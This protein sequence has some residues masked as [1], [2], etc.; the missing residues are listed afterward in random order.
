MSTHFGV[1]IRP[2]ADFGTQWIFVDA[3]PDAQDGLPGQ[4]ARPAFPAEV[5]LWQQRRFLELA[6]ALAMQGLPVQLP[7]PSGKKKKKRR[8]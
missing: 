7:A 3:G 6:E 8:F 4:Y 2:H 5:R 1:E